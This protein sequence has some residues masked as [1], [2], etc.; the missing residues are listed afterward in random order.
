M[1]ALNGFLMTEKQMTLKDVCW[2]VVLESFIGHVHVTV[3]DAF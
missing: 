3:S 1:K 2:Y